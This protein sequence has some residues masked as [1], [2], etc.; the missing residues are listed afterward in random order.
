MQPPLDKIVRSGLARLRV[1]QYYFDEPLFD[2]YEATTVRATWDF[3]AAEQVV[4][5]GHSVLDLGCGDGR[6]LLHLAGKFTLADSVG[7]DISKIA[8]DRFA[9][10]VPAAQR[11]R[12]H[13]RLGDVFDLPADIAERRFDTVAF[14]DA[15]VNF[16]LED[17]RLVELLRTGHDRLRDGSGRMLIAVFADGTPERLAFLDGR[18]TVVPFR[19]SDGRTS[20]IWWAY[21]FD[22]ERLVLRRSAFVQEGWSDDG[23]VEGVVCDLR[24]RL[25][26]PGSVAPLAESAGLAVETVVGSAV[27]DGAAVGMPTAVMVLKRM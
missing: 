11:K 12:L 6:L 2:E 10:R 22:A 26:T 8:I 18:T 7:V 16:V 19:A 5:D 27:Q 17:D 9:A 1:S 4:G 14:G 13:P 24:D 3:P 23:A 25:W 20:L 15:T 21:A